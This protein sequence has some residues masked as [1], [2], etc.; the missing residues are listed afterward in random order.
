MLKHVNRFHRESRLT[1]QKINDIII[2][3]PRCLCIVYAFH[4][5]MSLNINIAQS[6]ITIS[7]IEQFQNL[8]M[9]AK[10]ITRIALSFIPT[11]V[12]IITQL[13]SSR[14]IACKLSGIRLNF[15]MFYY[16]F[17]NSN[18]HMSLLIYYVILFVY[19]DQDKRKQT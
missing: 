1:L 13:K 16:F 10:L 17:H 7:A 4:T 6:I 15:L 3:H 8:L 5:I 18:I 12:A 14:Y 19:H 11:F 2:A 9:R